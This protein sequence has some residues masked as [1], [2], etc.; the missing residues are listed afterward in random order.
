MLHMFCPSSPLTIKDPLIFL[1]P[2]HL[3]KS[4][5]RRLMAVSHSLVL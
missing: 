1:E 5:T 2:D 3:S 4:I